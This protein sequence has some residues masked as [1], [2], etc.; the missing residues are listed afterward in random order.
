M[1][2]L[3]LLLSCLVKHAGLGAS[4]QSTCLICKAVQD[5]SGLHGGNKSRLQLFL[6]QFERPQLPFACIVTAD[7]KLH[8]ILHL[9]RPA[10]H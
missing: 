4:L 8:S 10:I 9:R 1:Q 2:S 6:V 3:M 5:P 7:F